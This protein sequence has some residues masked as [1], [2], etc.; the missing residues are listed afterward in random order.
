VVNEAKSSARQDADV[1]KVNLNIIANSMVNFAREA[2]KGVAIVGGTRG[3][4]LS[5]GA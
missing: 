5:V 3:R 1:K 4:A 2:L